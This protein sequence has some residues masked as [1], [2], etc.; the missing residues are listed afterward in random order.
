MDYGI[1][2]QNQACG[3]DK[4][5]SRTASKVWKGSVPREGTA[6]VVNTVFDQIKVHRLGL[7]RLEVPR[8]G[9]GVRVC[10]ELDVFAMEKGIVARCKERGGVGQRNLPHQAWLTRTLFQRHSF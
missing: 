2:D 9:Y 10:A 5:G 4:N 8:R 3:S 1:E 6:L 7:E